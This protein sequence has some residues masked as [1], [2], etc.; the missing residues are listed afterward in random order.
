[1]LAVILSITLLPA[2]AFAESGST[3]SSS[4]NAEEAQEE[5]TSEKDAEEVKPETHKTFTWYKHKLKFKSCKVLT[6]KKLNANYEPLDLKVKVRRNSRRLTWTE[7]RK[8]EKLDGYVVLRK[9]GK[10]RYVELAVLPASA[11]S[12]TDRGI[13][14]K[15][16]AE[17]TIIGYR[18]DPSGYGIRIS[19][20][21]GEGRN[22]SRRYQN[23]S[24]YVQITD[25]IDKHGLKYYTSP[26]LVNKNSTKKDHI[27]A[28]IKTAYKYKGDKY[29]N[30]WSRAPGKGVDC[31]GLVMQAC[32]GAGVDL[33]PSNP[34]R[35]RW[36][37]A[38]YE[39]ES[40]EIAKNPKLRTV[41]YSKR[42]RGDLIFFCNSSGTIIHVA[43]YLGNDKIIHS[44]T[45]GGH[46]VV[47]GMGGGAYG[48]PC[49]VKRIFN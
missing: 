42:K 37:A 30:R 32:Y 23:P 17:Y 3:E 44:T 12:Y 1:M 7:P 43:I 19:P 21:S 25:K 35:H 18:E 26:V 45:V 9:K 40:R 11:K 24:K 48:R 49:K 47:T 39:W 2:G 38:K 20:C 41:S 6:E 13:K 46:V 14:K 5:Q 22:P 29:A 28:L 34:H 4:V 27:N 36:G 16:K 33:W 31:S 8:V 10:G 15:T